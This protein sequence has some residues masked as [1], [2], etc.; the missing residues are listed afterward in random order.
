MKELSDS[1]SN[2]WLNAYVAG[3]AISNLPKGQSSRLLMQLKGERGKTDLNIEWNVINESI[4]FSVW[5]DYDFFSCRL[6]VRKR[7]RSRREVKKEKRGSSESSS[8]E[9]RWILQHKILLSLKHNDRHLA[10]WMWSFQFLISC[11]KRP[12]KKRDA[13]SSASPRKAKVSTKSTKWVGLWSC[14]I[15]KNILGQSQ[16]T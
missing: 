2:C 13:S 12:K 8:E 14:R 6:S 11:S 3:L 9:E 15:K 7:Q 4:H 1:H 5:V 16:A 10:L